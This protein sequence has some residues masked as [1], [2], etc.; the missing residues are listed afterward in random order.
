MREMKVLTVVGA[1]PQFIK[2]VMVCK[3]IDR[4]NETG[5]GPKLVEELVHTGQHYDPAVSQVFFDEL[6]IREPAVNLKVGSGGHGWMTGKMLIGLERELEERCPD[7][8]LVYGDTNSTLAGALCAAK[9]NVPV[10]HVESGLRSFNNSMPEEINRILTDRLSTLLFCPTS[11]AVA[12]LRTEGI[13]QG[14]RHEMAAK[15]ILTDSGGVQ[16][17]A[18]FHGVPCI[19]LRDETEWTE[20]V[21][22]G[23]NTLVGADANA[24]VDACQKCETGRP[25]AEYGDGHASIRIVEGLLGAHS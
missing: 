21:S 19:T 2:A 5:L 22:H 12:N 11:T 10:A 17:E 24:I 23:W 9:L 14:V 18:Y 7:W 6:G 13:S 20:T 4:H 8:V 25:I 3:A 1:R 16:K 15:A